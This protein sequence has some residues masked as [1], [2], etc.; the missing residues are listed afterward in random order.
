M[1][2]DTE[3]T[4]LGRSSSVKRFFK[5]ASLGAAKG[6]FSSS[7]GPSA[8]STSHPSSPL[9]SPSATHTRSKPSGRPATADNRS[10]V[11]LS[12][13][14]ESL[15]ISDLKGRKTRKR[16]SLIFLKGGRG[17][18]SK[19]DDDSGEKPEVDGEEEGRQEKDDVL[20]HGLEGGSPRS[21]YS[22]A[23]STLF[24][25]SPIDINAG[26]Q[27]KAK[28]VVAVVE[29]TIESET[30][31]ETE[32][33]EKHESK[34]APSPSPRRE[35]FLDMNAETARSA[36]GLN[37]IRRSLTLGRRQF[38]GKRASRASIPID[39][40]VGKGILSMG[41]GLGLGVGVSLGAGYRQDQFGAGFGG[42]AIGLGDKGEPGPRRSL[43][44][45]SKMTVSD[46]SVYYD[47]AEDWG[48]AASV[49]AGGSCGHSD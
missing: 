19:D 32:T 45:R 47:A 14:C 26:T 9:L 30:E 2:R 7:N 27:D 37:G 46:Q 49:K 6:P 31:A 3:K 29:D 24:A 38:M 21:T 33:E 39:V 43:S 40:D 16:R 17:T 13:P 4:P 44:Q 5:R 20:D 28:P 25:T 35:S 11:S 36:L 42:A 41:Q 15:A 10:S 8:W 1:D 12:S 48:S 34:P 23:S 18:P 22:S